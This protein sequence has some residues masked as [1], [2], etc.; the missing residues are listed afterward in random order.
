MDSFYGL[1][2]EFT[3]HGLDAFIRKLVVDQTIASACGKW[4]FNHIAPDR[5]AELLW[6]IGFLGIG[7]GS[8]V[9]RSPGANDLAHP[10]IT[11][12]ARFVIHGT[13]QAAL[14]L[15]NKVVADLDEGYLLRQGGVLY[16][17]PDE[18]TPQGYQQA[19]AT[20][21]EDLRTLPTGDADGDAKAFEDIVGKMIRYCFYRWLGNA[22]PKARNFNGRVIRDWF[23]AN[24]AN[25]G[26]WEAI[27]HRYDAPHIIWEC[28]NYAELGSG[29]FHQANYYL[30][31]PCGGCCV[32]AYRGEDGKKK[33]YY[34]HISRIASARDGK[35][36]VLLVNERDLQV[37]IRQ[38]Q[39]GKTRDSHIRAIYDDTIRAIS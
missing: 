7:N 27:R 37:F 32:I 31:Q 3:L 11:A 14:K 8:I 38:A 22:E 18:L 23:V 36:I 9:F 21:A 29:D 12:A 39:S 17:L 5:F 13:Y 28:K 33:S 6:N 10:P 34:E 30:T 4:I 2:A 16:E 26:F 19:L 35:G 15:Q 1:G 25:E 20:L 24:L